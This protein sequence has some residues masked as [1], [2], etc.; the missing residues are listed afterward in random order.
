MVMKNDLLPYKLLSKIQSQACY[1]YKKRVKEKWDLC[2]FFRTNALF[3]IE[4][5]NLFDIAQFLLV[6]YSILRQETTKR[7]RCVGERCLFFAD[8]SASVSLQLYYGARFIVCV[9]VL[10]M[11]DWYPFLRRHCFT[12]ITPIIDLLGTFYRQTDGRT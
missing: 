9:W 5:H 11:W 2:N 12:N 4:S 7:G 6:R 3:K 1:R 10:M 8:T